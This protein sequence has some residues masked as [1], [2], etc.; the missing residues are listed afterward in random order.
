MKVTA[1]LVDGYTYDIRTEGDGGVVV[2]GYTY[3]VRP[4][5]PTLL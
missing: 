1:V 4:A 3:D 5:T 2:D